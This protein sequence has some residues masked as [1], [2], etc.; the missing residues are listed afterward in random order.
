M[1]NHT[2]PE[3]SLVLLGGLLGS[4]HC[5]GMCGGFALTV[6]LGSGHWRINLSRQVTYTLGRVTTYMFLGSLAGFAGWRLTRWTT[7]GVLM[8]AL[9]AML[10]GGWLIWQG[11][12]SS[13][14]WRFMTRRGNSGAVGGSVCSA[15][16]VLSAFLQSGRLQDTLVAGVL[17]GFLPCGLVY[18]YL[19]L[20]ASTTHPVW[21]ALTMGLFGLG[22]APLMI[23]T[24]LGATVLSLAGRR[25]LLRL[26]TLAVI[27][28]GMLT[29]DRGIR[30]AWAHLR[31]NPQ[32]TACPYCESDLPARGAGET[33]GDIPANSPPFGPR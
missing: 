25:N 1:T 2:M 15:K 10:A 26:A 20:A 17:T 9:L 24:G 32:A 16:S 28:T 23:S 22:T 12:V 33:V 11:A 3:L 18:A 30:F 6:G 7:G 19:A 27:V 29:I 5:L 14:L 21:G 31:E 13:G 4:S 8:Q